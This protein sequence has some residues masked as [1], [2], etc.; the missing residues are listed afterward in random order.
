V[1]LCWLRHRRVLHAPPSGDRQRTLP[2]QAS[3][4]YDHG[5]GLPPSPRCRSPTPPSPIT[6]Q[7]VPD[8]PAQWCLAAL[9]RWLRGMLPRKRWQGYIVRCCF[10]TGMLSARLSL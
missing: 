6:S 1:S 8:R 2:L 9:L 3:E 7:R 10:E 5:R 4:S